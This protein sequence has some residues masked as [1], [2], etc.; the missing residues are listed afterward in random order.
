MLR[1]EI[2]IGR[3][4]IANRLS[5]GTTPKRLARRGSAYT[6]QLVH[7]R[8][9][10]VKLYNEHS[11]YGPAKGYQPHGS[12]ATC[13][14][15]YDPCEDVVLR[16]LTWW[17]WR[18]SALVVMEQRKSCL[19]LGVHFLSWPHAPHCRYL[20]ASNHYKFW[21]II[22]WT[23]GRSNC[24]DQQLASLPISDYYIFPRQSSLR[25]CK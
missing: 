17:L 19:F 23:C 14:E 10:V 2:T 21:M 9:W 15:S 22:W 3:F 11:I 4:C 20:T 25:R 13:T 5:Q 18:L 24:P 8:Y 7:C 12:A 1:P 16:R 6:T